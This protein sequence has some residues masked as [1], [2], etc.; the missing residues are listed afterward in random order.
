MMSILFIQTKNRKINKRGENGMRLLLA[1]AAKSNQ[2]QSSAIKRQ[3]MAET[4]A[5]KAIMVAV[6]APVA[7]W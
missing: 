7:G 4:N 5:V 6:I 1:A 3:P 2:K